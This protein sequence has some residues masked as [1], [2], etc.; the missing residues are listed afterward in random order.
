M[1]RMIHKKVLVA[2]FAIFLLSLSFYSCETVTA[3]VGEVAPGL[4]QGISIG[5]QSLGIPEDV[6]GALARSGVD[7]GLVL[8]RNTFEEIT[9]EGEYFL[10]R[11]VAATIL[12]RYSLQTNMPAVTAYLN[13]IAHALVV[14]SIRPELF[15][16]YRVGILDTDEINAFATPGGHIFLTRGLIESTTSEDTLAA[17][18]A[19][20]IA[21]I[22]LA[23]GF[24]AIR[25]SR[26]NEAFAQAA[27]DVGSA[28]SG[29]D[30]ENVTETFGLSV[31]LVVDTMISGYS[32]QQEFDADA[33]AMSLLALAGY[34]PSALIEV[35]EVLQRN[36]PTRSGG[37]NSTHP[38][39][40]DRI[41][42]ARRIVGNFE[43]A[44]TRSYR[45]ARHRAIM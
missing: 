16:G 17:V 44:D 7:I 14:N 34:N 5:L 33:V 22:Q 40:A 42:N 10:G 21:H 37:F 1:K 3:A 19:H 43:V 29:F 25:N 26:V 27:F 13:Q 23:H 8:A 32:R 12:T 20:E 15:H 4:A 6:A 24:E 41:S 2:V 9:P 39:P 30:L 28:A 36:Q 11:A 35:L 18:I 31:D 38:S 45:V